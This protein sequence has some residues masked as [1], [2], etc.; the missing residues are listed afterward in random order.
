MPAY[1]KDLANALESL[2]WS[3]PFRDS[4]GDP[5]AKRWIRKHWNRISL[6]S[7]FFSVGMMLKIKEVVLYA[8]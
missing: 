6:F 3:L 7:Y 5:C 1:V 8:M 2:G 4:S